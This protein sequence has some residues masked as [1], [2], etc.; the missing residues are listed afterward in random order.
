MKKNLEKMAYIL[1]NGNWEERLDTVKSLSDFSEEKSLLL[2]IKSSSDEDEFVR[3]AVAKGLGKRYDETVFPSLIKLIKDDDTDVSNAAFMS[4]KNFKKL[5]P[6]KL[7]F[8]FK[9]E[10]DIRHK[11]NLI[12][13]MG[14][15]KE[16][17]FVKY[18][19]D[20]LSE[21]NQ[22]LRKEAMTALIKTGS[23]EA[24]KPLLK[25]LNKLTP[26]MK[27][28]LSDIL[29]KV[30]G[31]SAIISL[32]RLLRDENPE[33]RYRSAFYLGQKK[34]KRAV[35]LLIKGLNDPVEK[36]RVGCAGA[37]LNIGYIKSLEAILNF[38]EKAN[39]EELLFF[40]NFNLFEKFKKILNNH[41]NEG[42]PEDIELFRRIKR[43]FSR[44]DRDIR[45]IASKKLDLLIENSPGDI[46][47][48]EQKNFLSPEEKDIELISTI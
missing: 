23:C 38:L 46:V 7:I 37:L 11:K 31:E 6:E 36:V 26:V 34:N 19:I 17:S 16:P 13:L 21:D 15:I 42:T 5:S 48:I 43:K 8:Y 27:L 33:V 4:L 25:I 22:E 18:F 30:K 3:E 35:S 2:L 12:R 1:E 40:F 45:L 32:K 41:P 29:G 10:K 20:L 24:I 28:E 47:I 14:E 9:K 39:S 44:Y